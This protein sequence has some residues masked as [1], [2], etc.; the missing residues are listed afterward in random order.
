MSCIKINSFLKSVFQNG[1][2]KFIFWH[3][4]LR[5]TYNSKNT[6]NLNQ[7]PTN[8]PWK[9]K[10]SHS[11]TPFSHCYLFLTFRSQN[12]EVLYNTLHNIY[13]PTSKGQN[14]K[15][16]NTSVSNYHHVKLAFGNIIYV[17]PTWSK[18]INRSIHYYEIWDNYAS[19]GHLYKI[20][21]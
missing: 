4:T 17:N 2:Y 10:I 9:S 20:N 12:I 11:H 1:K 5:S 18:F 21:K 3:K 13:L 8:K 16:Q 14:S 7:E 15:I 19:M 6:Y